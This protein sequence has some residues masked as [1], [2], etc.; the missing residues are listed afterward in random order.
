MT[1]DP[2]DKLV[3]IV[4]ALLHFNYLETVIT[5]THFCKYESSENLPPFLPS[6]SLL[7]ML[8]LH[9]EYDVM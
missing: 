2:Y 7:W 4:P 1:Q 6:S 3:D 5:D 9:D 8:C